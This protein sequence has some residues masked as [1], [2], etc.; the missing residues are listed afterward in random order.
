MWWIVSA[1]PKPISESQSRV[2]FGYIRAVDVQNKTIEF[3]DAV[4][5]M[6]KDAE[7]AALAEGHCTEETRSDCVPNDYYILNPATSTVT[8]PLD[9]K[10]LVAMMTLHAESESIKETQISFE[11]FA[12]LLNDTQ[13]PWHELP[14][15]LFEDNNS[16]TIIEEVYVP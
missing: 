5:L 3:D 16:I 9:T 11:E 12:R 8:L 14:Y 13:L 10:V 1:V 4:W 6:G 2:L 7:E 15:Q